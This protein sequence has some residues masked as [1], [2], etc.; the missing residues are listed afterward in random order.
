MKKLM[1]LCSIST[2]LCCMDEKR[3][4]DEIQS[5]L[6]LR[7]LVT[8]VR[9]L[10]QAR[11]FKPCDCDAVER[12][13]FALELMFAKQHAQE[14]LKELIR[15]RSFCP[16]DE[17][18]KKAAFTYLL[19][20]ACATYQRIDGVIAHQGIK[21]LVEELV[22]HAG[23]WITPKTGTSRQAEKAPAESREQRKSVSDLSKEERAK[24]FAEQRKQY[25]ERKR[26]PRR[27]QE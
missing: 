19:V 25:A 5:I 23:K 4:L 12:G 7:E 18:L 15:L 13:E 14:L 24:I 21:S 3:V 16:E 9:V 27:K 20:R 26:L 1:L 8:R 6:E 17:R 10:E 2:H 22:E 11:D